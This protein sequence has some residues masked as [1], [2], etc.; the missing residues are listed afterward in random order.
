[1]QP[2]EVFEQEQ[3]S[4]AIPVAYLLLHDSVRGDHSKAKTILEG[5]LA[6]FGTS[7]T[8]Y[9]PINSNLS[10]R[11]DRVSDWDDWLLFEPV[12]AHTASSRDLSAETAF[13]SDFSSRPLTRT[14]SIASFAGGEQESRHTVEAAVTHLTNAMTD[15]VEEGQEGLGDM[16]AHPLSQSLQDEAE[17]NRLSAMPGA[18]LS[19]DDIARYVCLHVYV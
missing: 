13:S 2:P 5:M 9:L 17:Y 14:T 8:F 16:A 12:H 18:F 15:D 4:S 7:A 11:K 1:M 10:P 6:R 19:D 3:L